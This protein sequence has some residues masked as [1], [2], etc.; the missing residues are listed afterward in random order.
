MKKKTVAVYARGSSKKMQQ[1][2]EKDIEL[3]ERRMHSREIVMQFY[4]L[5]HTY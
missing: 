5:A 2:K 4:E 3:E 1:L